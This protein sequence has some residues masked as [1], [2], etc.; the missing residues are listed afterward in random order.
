MIGCVVLVCVVF[1]LAGRNPVVAANETGIVTAES[2]NVRSAAGT[3]NTSI[4]KITKGTTVTILETTQDSTGA[5]WYKI[6]VVQNGSEVTGY[7]SAAYI[8][9]GTEVT[10]TSTVSAT[11]T[12]VPS[13]TAAPVS[14][15]TYRNETTYS[16]I[17]IPAKILKKAVVY[18]KAGGSQKK[19]AK[20]KVSLP[21]K[22]K[23]KLLGEKTVK[24]QKYFKIRFKWKGK[25][26]TG[27]VKNQ[28][29]QITSATKAAVKITNVKAKVKVR[30]KAGFS[31]AYLK[32]GSTVISIPKNTIVTIKKDTKPKKKTARWYQVSFSYNGKTKKGYIHSKYTKLTKKPTVKK[33]KVVALSDTD[34]EKMLTQQG[35]PDSYKDSLRALHKSYPFWEFRAYQTGVKWEDALANECKLGVNLISNSKSV[36]WKS[37]EEGAYDASTGT[38]KVFDG[39]SWVA[40]S[41]TAISYYMDP[42]NFLNDRNIFQFELLEYQS[43]YQTK[44]GVAIILNNTP[45]SNQ[46]Y[47]Y[48]DIST[49]KDRTITYAD[50]FIEAAASSG[51][52]PYHLASRMKQEVVT[53]A[54]TVSS[55]VSGN[56]STYP[57][58]YNFY[59]I[60]AV[61][62]SNPVANGLKW[63]STGTTYLRPWTNPYRSI[64]G[65][66][67]YIG[68]SYI[69][70][71]QN[72]LYLEKFNV[73]A[74]SRY[75]HQYMT[76]VEAAYSESIKTKK[77]YEE[78]L[79]TT[80][81]V[82]SI[83]VYEEMPEAVSVAPN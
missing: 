67:S 81:I 47:T 28:L 25:T 38:W 68:T 82:F 7:V 74:N 34:F 41:S 31:S 79:N 75:N 19:I 83:P 62:S 57:G 11:P 16:E 59:N 32:D 22:K 9:V 51:V 54:T 42:R 71:G 12:P 45:Y 14:T 5:S 40:A 33:V 26:R 69:N 72:T 37:T 60:G 15:V 4:T 53:S 39:T 55:A 44:D 64:V 10:P 73:T 70:K 13:N 46:S 43:Q 63:A 58:I 24:N 49:G 27:Y 52:S 29:I 65:G 76:N 6:S 21:K 23:I 36:A 56:H 35:F 61:S 48:P 1:S 50:T 77:A 66:A 3:E 17:L 18:K 20:K 78:M 30:K 80:P 8:A 2:L